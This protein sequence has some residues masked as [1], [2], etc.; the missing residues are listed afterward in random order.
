M[1][2]RETSYH[3]TLEAAEACRSAFLKNYP[4]N[5]Y[6]SRCEIREADLVDGETKEPVKGFRVD[7]SHYGS[8]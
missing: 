5:P 4:S 8:N 1:P 7:A 2:F 6:E 3:L